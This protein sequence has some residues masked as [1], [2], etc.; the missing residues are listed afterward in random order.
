M[1]MKKQRTAS[2][3]SKKT[4]LW[5]RILLN[6]QV[7]VLLLPGLIWYTIFCYM[8]MGGLSLAF[9]TYKAN[10]GIWMSPWIGLQNYEFV[11]RDPDFF[12][13]LGNTV[14][15]SF[16]RILFQFPVPII[17]ALLINE[18]RSQRYKK[19]LQTIYTFP[20]FLSW[21][22]VASIMLNLLGNNGTVNAMLSALGME[23]INF[24]GDEKIFRP[25][26]YITENWK[27]AGW[28]AIIYMAAISGID[29][30]QYEAAD[31]DGAGRLMKMVY[32]TLPCIKPTIVV[33]F[34]LAVGGIMNAGF[35]QI[36]NLSNPAV[37]DV[38]DILDTYIYRITFQSSADFS[39]STAISLFKSVINFIFLISCDR[40]SKLVGEN[41]LF[42]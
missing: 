12:R 15:I 34:I 24:L 33:M 21:V 39:F 31:I 8:P 25:I 35:D 11:F 7:Y 22:I 42:A 40:V 30:E 28:S 9:K 18:I 27:G 38:S 2:S 6:W 23:P 10:L 29:T 32:I 4:S 13:A 3:V 14:V 20:H 36:F 17:L 1:T 26:L 19:V 41:G 5:K 16:C 37:R